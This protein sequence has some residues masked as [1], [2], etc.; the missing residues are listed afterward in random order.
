MTVIQRVT[1]PMKKA[2]ESEVKGVCAA[3]SEQQVPRELSIDSDEKFLTKGD[4]CTLGYKGY[5]GTDEECFGEKVVVRPA[6]KSEQINFHRI[7]DPKYFEG[8]WVYAEKGSAS[9]RNKNHLKENNMKFGIIHKA[10]S[11]KHFSRSRKIFNKIISRKRWRVEQN[12]GI[13]KRKF[14]TREQDI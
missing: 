6:N 12:F 3:D 2:T 11:N 8:R 7:A 13:L 10:S 14:K 9:R 4:S 1:R 5:L